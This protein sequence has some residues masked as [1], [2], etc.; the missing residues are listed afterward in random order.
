VADHD[1]IARAVAGELDLASLSPAEWR[2]ANAEIDAR[3]WSRDRPGFGE[4]LAAEGQTT[5][6]LDD[7]GRVTEY[8]PDS[9]TRLLESGN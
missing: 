9:T 8:Y 6:A 3:I 1:R 7:E 2:A 5:V 4:I